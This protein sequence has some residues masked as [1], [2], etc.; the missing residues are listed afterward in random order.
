MS[1]IVEMIY[2]AKRDKDN[3]VATTVRV[4][5]ETQLAIE[6]LADYLSI[7]KQETMVKLMEA[8][9]EIAENAKIE[10]ETMV[11]SFYLLNTNKRYDVDMHR[12]MLDLGHAAATYEPWKFKINKIVEGDIVFLYEN[13]VG[14]VGYG[15]GTGKTLTKEYQG[16]ESALHYQ[17]LA[18]FK[19][20]NSPLKASTIKD[21]L[22]RKIL[23][24]RVMH[25]MPDGQKLVDYIEANDS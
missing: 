5:K 17:E 20:L 2:E 12:N 13:G 25:S 1:G 16:D 11:S 21:I 24:L 10:D 15:R 14:I 9:L 6:D 19:R 4:P 3:L 18:A 7:S 23:F 8:G 22:D